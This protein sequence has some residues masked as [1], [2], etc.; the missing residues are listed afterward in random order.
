M[1]CREVASESGLGL[2]TIYE[3]IRQGEL[4]YRMVGRWHIVSRIAYQNWLAAFGMPAPGVTDGK[5]EEEANA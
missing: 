4:P 3:S 1:T 5:R 2:Q